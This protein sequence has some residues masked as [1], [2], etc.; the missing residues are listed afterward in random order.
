MEIKYPPWAPNDLCE[1][2]KIILGHINSKK[3][4]MTKTK[5]FEILESLIFN[6]EMKKVW[7]IIKRYSVLGYLKN[8]IFS[9]I[10]KEEDQLYIKYN[11]YGFRLY[12]NAL[13]A[14]AYSVIKYKSKKEKKEFY[15]TI[16][17]LSSELSKLIKKSEF[18]L[19]PRRYHSEYDE[20]S[21]KGKLLFE[22]YEIGFEMSNVLLSLSCEAEMSEAMVDTETQVLP[23]PNIKNAKRTAFIR[24][25]SLCFMQD[26]NSYLYRT[27]ATLA[28]CVLNDPGIYENTIKDALRN[29]SGDS[30]RISELKIIG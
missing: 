18:D 2:H 13:T 15:R 20:L 29:W 5:R 27:Q 19:S 16:K 26:Y 22:D 7:L 28:R 24:I 14:Y 1:H 11:T 17:N 9:K 21:D 3:S 25:L 30:D 12:T 4:K 8:P 23:Y 6:E 10:P